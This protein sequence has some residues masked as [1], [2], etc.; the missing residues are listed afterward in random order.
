MLTRTNTQTQRL[1]LRGYRHTCINHR[2]NELRLF[3]FPCRGEDTRDWQ[4]H[5]W[6][7]YQA[8]IDAAHKQ[9]ADES[10]TEQRIDKF[11]PY[12]FDKSPFKLPAHIR[13]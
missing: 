6:E 3:S 13:S 2:L 8:G 7:A 5:E 1:W 4:E 12:S 10:S 9:K 11:T